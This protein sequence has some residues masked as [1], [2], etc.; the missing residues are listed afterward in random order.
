MC[1]I[2]KNFRKENKCTHDIDLIDHAID[3]HFTENV[4]HKIPI[5]LHDLIERWN[6]FPTLKANE[7]II[8]GEKHFK[9]ADHA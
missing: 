3:S 4:L 2:I 7:K 9:V 1:E 5:E 8:L 6:Y